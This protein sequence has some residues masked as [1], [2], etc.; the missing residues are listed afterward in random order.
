LT[1]PAE[2]PPTTVYDQEIFDAFENQPFSSIQEF[3]KLPCIPTVAVHRGVTSPL[4]FVV[5]H[6]PWFPSA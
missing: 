2:D 1:L 5:K 4:G 3:D 6:F